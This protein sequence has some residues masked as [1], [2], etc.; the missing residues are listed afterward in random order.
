VT[1]F[2]EGQNDFYLEEI[3]EPADNTL[4][5]VVIEAAPR[6]AVSRSPLFGKVQEIAP[7]PDSRRLELVWDTY[8]AY[9]VR[10]ESFVLG[11]PR[12]VPVKLREI[13][14]SPFLSFVTANTVGVD[15]E[16][17]HWEL[18]C[19]NH[20]IDVASGSGPV[21]TELSVRG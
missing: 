17:R 16:L 14:D 13:Q 3:G 10:N 9:A 12:A 2:P 11:D 19:L 5:L 1:S 18:T 21:I 7:G 6:G 20:V 15:G 4:R 8:I